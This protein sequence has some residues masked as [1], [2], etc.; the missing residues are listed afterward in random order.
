MIQRDAK[1]GIDIYE[2]WLWC[3]NAVAAA[4]D[5]DIPDGY[6]QYGVLDNGYKT[7]NQRESFMPSVCGGGLKRCFQ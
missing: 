5:P 7:P 4:T 1:D 3:R 6:W 2:L